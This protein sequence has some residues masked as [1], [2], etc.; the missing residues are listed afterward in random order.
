MT[1]REARYPAT[2]RDCIVCHGETGDARLIPHALVRPSIS[3]L[4]AAD[5][6]EWAEGREIC[7]TDLD[8]YLRAHI[9]SLLTEDG[10][11]LGE[12]EHEVLDSIV[13]RTPISQPP[14]DE[15]QSFGQRMADRVAAFGGSWTFIMGFGVILFVWMTLNATALLF[16]AFDPYPFI[17]LNLVLSCIA[18]MQAP[19]IMMSQRRQDEKDR[20][21]AE[22][23][24]QVG[25][26]A[27]LEIRQLH[28]KIDHHII[29]QW[30]QSAKP[31]RDPVEPPANG[32]EGTPS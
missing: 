10:D 3:V 30:R 18:A 5:C 32:Q 22:K 25:L 7:R 31:R 28:E 8:A 20:E 26:K 1:E 12:L 23:A 27:E 9:A 11:E 19:I 15:T 24:Y 2:S 29:A 17:L 13:D 6:P 21:Q 14:S 16:R 4:V